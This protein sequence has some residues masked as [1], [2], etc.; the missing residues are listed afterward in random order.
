MG[1]AR[2]V[3][4]GGLPRSGTTLL[5]NVISA[6]PAV[7]GLETD[8]SLINNQARIDQLLD[9]PLNAHEPYLDIFAML[10]EGRTKVVSGISRWP[11]SVAQ[12][13]PYFRQ[14]EPSWSN[15]FCAM[16]S[17]S[18]ALVA[19]PILL[20]KSPRIERYFFHLLRDAEACGLDLRSV[21]IVRSPRTSYLSY[22]H[23]M[24]FFRGVRVSLPNAAGWGELWLQST[25]RAL[26]FA[27][28]YPGH[29][30][31]VRFEDLVE[32]PTPVVDRLTDELA[33]P[34]SGRAPMIAALEKPANTS[35][36]NQRRPIL[37][38]EEEDE[39]AA[40]CGERAISLGYQ[41][42]L[43]S[44][45]DRVRRPNVVFGRLA[46]LSTQELTRALPRVLLRRLGNQ[47]KLATARGRAIL[48]RS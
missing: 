28:A 38:A 31:I 32:D 8:W 44:D 2:V 10:Q 7:H 30:M 20:A 35:F 40:T 23:S 6:N 24:A 1:A 17:A 43:A 14:A 13:E 29:S 4:V 21:Y 18:C 12:I 26:D 45:D 19:E 3:L 16:L 48:D 25:G 39:L 22:K 41:L 15:L 36:P 5:R 37:S 42:P 11:V 47:L 33:L 46:S 27:R 9:A 34:E